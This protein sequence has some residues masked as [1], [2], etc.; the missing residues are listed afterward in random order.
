MSNTQIVQGNAAPAARVINTTSDPAM[1]QLLLTS[2]GN[3]QF[4]N[5]THRLGYRALARVGAVYKYL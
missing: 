1:V 3:F 2:K 5:D 4:M